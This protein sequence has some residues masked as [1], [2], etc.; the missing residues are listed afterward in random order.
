MT[1]ADSHLE[2]SKRAVIYKNSQIYEEKPPMNEGFRNIAVLL[3]AFCAMNNN[4]YAQDN[5]VVIAEEAASEAPTVVYGAARKADGSEEEV[6]VEQPADAANPLG[7][8]IIPVAPTTVTTTPVIN[9]MPSEVKNPQPGVSGNGAGSEQPDTQPQVI[10]QPVVPEGQQLGDQFQNTLMEAN[11]MV[12]DV[13]AFPEEDLKAIG[14]PSNPETIYSP[15][16]NQ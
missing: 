14:N 7:D 12:Y 5:Q 11:G 10:G 13:Q 9:S 16:V 8:P 3:W 2:K 6:L 15:N 1:P 4:S